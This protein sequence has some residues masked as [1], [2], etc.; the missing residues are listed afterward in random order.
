MM[1]FMTLYCF[2]TKFGWKPSVQ[3][4]PGLKICL[5]VVL[6]NLE[7]AA[8]VLNHRLLKCGGRVIERKS[9]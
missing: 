1:T 6:R 8:R 4:S 5:A 7:T 3:H 9:E 2:E